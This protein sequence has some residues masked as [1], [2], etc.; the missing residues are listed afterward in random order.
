MNIGVKTNIFTH[1]RSLP[2]KFAFLTQNPQIFENFIFVLANPMLPS[3][4]MLQKML[5]TLIFTCSANMGFKIR[6]Q[7][8]VNFKKIPVSSFFC[9]FVFFNFNG[10]SL[11]NCF[12]ILGFFSLLNGKKVRSYNFYFKGTEES[13]SLFRAVELGE[14]TKGTILKVAL[15]S[16]LYV[17]DFYA[18]LNP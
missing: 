15:K 12:N 18:T 17:L 5:W 9:F 2:S 13:K 8:T 14:I 6:Q 11:K 3:L 4:K 7:L 1:L 16:C 10:L